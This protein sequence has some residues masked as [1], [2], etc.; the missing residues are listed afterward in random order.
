MR[1]GIIIGI[2]V[3]GLVLMG[4]SVP[5]ES[6]KLGDKQYFDLS[7]LI[8]EQVVLLSILNPTL[9]KRVEK[10]GKAEVL[11]ARLDSIQWST[12]LQSLAQVDINRSRLRDSYATSES[13]SQGDL[14]VVSY[15]LTDLHENGIQY[16]NVYRD[17]VLDNLLKIE[18]RKQESN[19][20]YESASVFEMNFEM[21]DIGDIFLRSYRISG[22]QTMLFSETIRFKIEGEIEY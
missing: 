18:A 15:Q 21:D 20:L 1:L 9:T 5:P 14:K 19:F 4:C 3:T 10:D 6:K 16:L 17:A 22:E 13:I 7:G 11:G 12:E 8:Q 2:A